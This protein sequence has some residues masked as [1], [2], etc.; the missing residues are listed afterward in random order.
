MRRLSFGFQGEWRGQTNGATNRTKCYTYHDTAYPVGVELSRTNSE[1][2]ATYK[3][4]PFA[5]VS[6]I[7]HQIADQQPSD[8]SA[9]EA[10]SEAHP[11]F[12]LLWRLLVPVSRWRW[13]WRWVSIAWWWG[14]VA[15]VGR[16]VTVASRWIRI[17]CCRCWR[18][19][20]WR[21][22]ACWGWSRIP[23]R[24]DL[25]VFCRRRYCN[26]GFVR[27]ARSPMYRI[28]RYHRWWWRRLL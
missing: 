16:R 6:G 12:V 14:W 3:K 7:R 22:M 21:G 8:Q 23:N 20:F 5:K 28:G 4:S 17:C 13:R 25:R 10:C 18:V 11:K 27:G 15:P 24:R 19:A 2:D 26:F 1:V 9:E